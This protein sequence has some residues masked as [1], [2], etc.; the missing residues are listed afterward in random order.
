MF[1]II[2]EVTLLTGL[3]ASQLSIASLRSTVAYMAKWAIII[4]TLVS[5]IISHAILLP[6]SS[7]TYPGATSLTS[8][9]SLSHIYAPQRQINVHLTNLALQTGITRFLE[10]PVPSSPLVIL[11]GSADGRYPAIRTGGTLWLYDKSDNSTG[12]YHDLGFWEKFEYAIVEDPE[13][14]L[15]VG[16]WDVVDKIASLGR[17]R[18]LGPDVGR[19][20]LVLGDGEGRREKDGVGKMIEAMYGRK[21]GGVMSWAYGVMHD[22]LREGYGMPDGRSLTGGS[23]VHWGMEWKLYVLKRGEK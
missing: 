8:L 17:P 21:L 5:A 10:N 2:P 9:H 13:H 7:L 15:P 20:L 12:A 23:W 11:P 18:V 3:A 4:S 6:L 22:V 19:G 14:A 16:G 1:P